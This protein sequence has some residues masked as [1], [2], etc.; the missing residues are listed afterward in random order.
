MYLLYLTIWGRSFT[1]TFFVR[2]LLVINTFLLS[3]T[4]VTGASSLAL[5]TCC[6]FENPALI[7]LVL[8]I[9][10]S[11]IPFCLC[12]W[13]SLLFFCHL[14]PLPLSP[15]VFWVLSNSSQYVLVFCNYNSWMY[16]VFCLHPLHPDPSPSCLLQALLLLVAALEWVWLECLCWMMLVFPVKEILILDFYSVSRRHP[17]IQVV[18]GR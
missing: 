2:A 5:S 11:Y 1:E 7:L 16:C 9:L 10:L 18:A 6:P 4:I 17:S 12:Q 3:S 13:Q 15:T 14:L 8:L